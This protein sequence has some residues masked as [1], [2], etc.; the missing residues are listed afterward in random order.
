V[1]EKGRKRTGIKTNGK[2]TGQTISK[3]W[4]VDRVYRSNYKNIILRGRR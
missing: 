4:R 3:K 1:K 2:K